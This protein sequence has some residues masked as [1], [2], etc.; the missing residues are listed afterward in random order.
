[1]ICLSNGERIKLPLKFGFLF[2]IDSLNQASPATISRCG[3]IY[4]DE[5]SLGFEMIIKSWIQKFIQKEFKIRVE[6]I[7]SN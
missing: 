6:D 5:S 4:L 1:M 3:M 2:E 7:K